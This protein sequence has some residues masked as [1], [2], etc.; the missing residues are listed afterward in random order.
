MRTGRDCPTERK[1]RYDLPQSR[2][3]PLQIVQTTIRYRIRSDGRVEQLVEGVRGDACETL[4]ERIEAR[5][6]T[7]RSRV[8]TSE[9][10]LP[11][12]SIQ[13][14]SLPLGQFSA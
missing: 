7:V 6:G 8:P 14:H 4:T 13:S 12:E 10:Y 11:S 1:R 3:A 9:A 2:C 5:I